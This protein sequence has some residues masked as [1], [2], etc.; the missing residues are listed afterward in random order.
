[1]K[2]FCYEH[3]SPRKINVDVRKS[4]IQSTNPGQGIQQVVDVLINLGEK[5]TIN[6]NELATL[7]EELLQKLEQ[8][9]ANVMPFRVTINL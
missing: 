7:K 1:V 6:P 9:S 5:S 2:A 8:N 4:Y 3:F